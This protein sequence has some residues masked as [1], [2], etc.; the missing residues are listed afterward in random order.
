MKSFAKRVLF[1]IFFI[2]ILL[3]AVYFGYDL[4]TNPYVLTKTDNEVIET[5]GKFSC[6]TCRYNKY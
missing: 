6:R 5:E 3:A 2:V 1:F 4:N